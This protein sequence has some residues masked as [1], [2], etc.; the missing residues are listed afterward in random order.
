MSHRVKVLT[1]KPGNL[2]LILGPD[3]RKLPPDL[4]KCA[5]TP[6][7]LSSFK[8]HLDRHGTSGR[9]LALN[10]P[11]GAFDSCQIFRV[12]IWPFAGS[13]GV[14]GTEQAPSPEETSACS[15]NGLD[16]SN[17]LWVTHLC[18]ETW[19]YVTSTSVIMWLRDTNHNQCWGFLLGYLPS[20]SLPTQQGVTYPS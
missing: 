18:P 10:T 6:L 8:F 2:S 1:A 17:D 12:S 16:L 15:D 13:A 14:P 4:H 20:P 9:F 19:N 11:N 7:P 3:S 5:P